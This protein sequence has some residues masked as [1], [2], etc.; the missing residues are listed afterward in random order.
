MPGMNGIELLTRIKEIDGSVERVLISAFEIGDDIF[1]ET[2][3]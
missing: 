1:K 3:V 2:N